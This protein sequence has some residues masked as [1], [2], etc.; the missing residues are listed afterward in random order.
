ME[1]RLDRQVYRSEIELATTRLR[2]TA[3]GGAAEMLAAKPT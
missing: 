1:G 3:A 2:P